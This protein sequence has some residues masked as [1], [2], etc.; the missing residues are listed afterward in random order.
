MKYYQITSE[1]RYTIST[2]RKQGYSAAKIALYLGRHPSSIYR[3]I[4]RNGCNDGRYRPSKASR[5]TRGRRSRSRRN[6][7]FTP[8][9][10]E[11]VEWL[12]CEKWSPE[13]ISGYLRKNDV[14]LMADSKVKCNFY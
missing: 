9:D 10:Y 8:Q 13:Q 5:R 2:L 4:R 7:Q 14:F 12:L 3:E 11:I 6:R 1:E